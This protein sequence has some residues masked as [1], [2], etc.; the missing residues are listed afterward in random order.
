MKSIIES[1]KEYSYPTL[2]AVL[3]KISLLDRKKFIPGLYNI[4]AYENKPVQI[5]H[6][7][8]ATKPSV[9]A[10]MAA[11]LNFKEGDRV[12]EIGL[13]CGYSAA[14]TLSLIGPTGSLI[15]FER[16][17]LLC[18]LGQKN[19]RA[20]S[21]TKNY[22]ILYDNGLFAPSKFPDSSFDKIYVTAGIDSVNHFPLDDFIKLLKPS[23]LLVFPEEDGSLYV[24][25]ASQK[26]KP[27]LI[28]KLDGFSF[29][30]L[31]RGKA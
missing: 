11:L 5:G 9:V 29:V 17:R 13:G 24:Y 4:S 14:L 10:L 16:I 15:S 22:T 21:S 27:F 23:G 30:P 31:K 2:P 26:K 28:E 12:L 7:Q 19:L 18:S 3:E 6:F 25:T 1:L 8:T 20:F